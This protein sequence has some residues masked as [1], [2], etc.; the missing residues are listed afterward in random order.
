MR[1]SKQFICIYAVLELFYGFHA[2]FNRCLV[3]GYEVTVSCRDA[4]GKSLVDVVE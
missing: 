1:K 2:L 4:L 3:E